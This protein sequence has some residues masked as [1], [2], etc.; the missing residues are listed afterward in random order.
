MVDALL[1][2]KVGMT[3]VYTEGGELVPVTV[4]ELGPCVVI[5]VKTADQDGY[6][7]LQLG[8]EE[9]KRKRVTRPLLGHY[10][11]A[12]VAPTRFLREV[13][14][15]GEGEM[16]PGAV[17]KADLFAEEQR[18]DV[19][20]V[21]KG[22]GFQGVVKRYG[23]AGGPKTHGQGDRHRAP[24]SIGQSAYPARVL[25]G[26]RMPGRMGGTRHTIRNLKV[27]KVDTERNAL[28]VRGAVPGPRTGY[29]VVRRTS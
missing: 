14:W 7:A 29:V 11:K 26:T 21:S 1:G 20:G 16:A 23:F 17:L 24:G 25:K 15:D 22:R 13:G 3:S 4:I 27:V 10:D 6:N 18:V 19:T 12:G 5:Q 8:F 2:K 28:L 9:K